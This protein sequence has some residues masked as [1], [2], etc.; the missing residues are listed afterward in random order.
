[1]RM[2]VGMI[3]DKEITSKKGNLDQQNYYSVNVTFTAN[4]H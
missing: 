3:V 2:K 4:Q 1:M